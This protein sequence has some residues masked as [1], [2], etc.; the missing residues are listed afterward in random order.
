MRKGPISLT[1][2]LIALLAAGLLVLQ[3]LIFFATVRFRYEEQFRMAA[4]DRARMAIT[5]H[6]LLSP[7]D[8]PERLRLIN[9]MRYESFSVRLAPEQPL[10]QD[11]SEHSLFLLRRLVELDEL[12]RL[13]RTGLSRKEL[14][15][16]A[17][18][19]IVTRMD[20]FRINWQTTFFFSMDMLSSHPR[21]GI[22]EGETGLAFND[23]AWL[24][25][26]Y[27]TVPIL[28]GNIS[29]LLLELCVQFILQM[30]LAVA[31]IRYLMRPLRQLANF[32]DRIAADVPEEAPEGLPERGP[33]EVART[34]QAFRAMYERIK[35]HVQERMRLLASISHDL[36][37]PIARLR[38]QL[39]SE[40]NLQRP[41]LVFDALD[42]LQNLAED[43]VSLA[44]T[45]A[46][47]E[48]ER[49]MD[50]AFLLESMAADYEEYRCTGAKGNEEAQVA[51]HVGFRPHCRLRPQAFRRCL[52]NLVDN[53]LR[54]GG[55]AEI[56]LEEVDGSRAL[57][58]IR[59][60]DRGA[61]IP[62][63]ELEKVF[64]PFYRL[65]HSRNQSTGGTGLGLS[66]ARDLARLNHAR[67]S[68][69]NLKES[70]LRVTLLIPACG[71]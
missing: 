26:T 31:V 12:P 47:S 36:R 59:I 38:M 61:G 30:T 27:Y 34:S 57:A 22:F 8:Y 13:E 52:E 45:G 16:K 37:T 60:E 3:F 4:S 5:L 70:G 44:R 35:R 64:Q 32:A 6:W 10:A 40:P 39:E 68:L 21:A 51:L 24:H 23:G 25:V 56:F 65:E 48:P 66:I 9:D 53:A 42:D 67:I 28:A 11:N 20:A 33:S 41:D 58:R 43:A 55:G 1:A 19:A 69:S 54:Y 29:D 63:R 62:E 49:K 50:L 46:N 15:D 7:L 14:L 2:L 71:A 17:D 18:G